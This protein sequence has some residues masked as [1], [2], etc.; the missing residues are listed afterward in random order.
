MWNR[1]NLSRVQIAYCGKFIWLASVPTTHW[2]FSGTVTQ[3]WETS[4]MLLAFKIPNPNALLT[5]K[6]APFFLQPALFF[7]EEYSAVHVIRCCMSRHVRFGLKR[8]TTNFLFVLL[9]SGFLSITSMHITDG[10]FILLNWRDIPINN[11]LSSGASN[12]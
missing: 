11:H 12:V 4:T 10:S 5:Q 1:F 9:G 8:Q 2:Y 7:R 3:F 6:P